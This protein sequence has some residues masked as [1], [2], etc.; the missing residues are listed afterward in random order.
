MFLKNWVIRGAV[1]LLAT[2][3]SE[4]QD[5]AASVGIPIT[6]QLT[7]DKCGGCHQ[8]DAN[9][10]MRRL[11][12]I[13]TTPEVWEQAIKRMIRLNGLVLKPEEAREILRYLSNNNGLAPEEAK[14]VFWEAEHGLF[15]GAENQL[16]PR[17]PIGRQAEAPVVLAAPT[18]GFPAVAAPP[19]QPNTNLRSD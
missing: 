1:V 19:P 13:R 17:R 18:G 6:H 2:S 8:R 16:R 15:P 3:I 4:A 11:S 9:G 10:M 5:S 7:L 14:P 12:Y